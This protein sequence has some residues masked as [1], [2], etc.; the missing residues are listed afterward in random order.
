MLKTDSKVT[1]K[2]DPHSRIPLILR[3]Y[4]FYAYICG[5]GNQGDFKR[6]LAHFMVADYN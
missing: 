6:L 4:S 3:L 1:L 5:T 2:H